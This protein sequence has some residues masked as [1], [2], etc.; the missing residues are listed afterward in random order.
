MT[1][2]PRFRDVGADTLLICRTN[3]RVLWTD[4]SFKNGISGWA[5][6]EEET[7]LHYDWE[8]GLTSNLAEGVAIRDALR[9]L[10]GGSGIV[11]TDSS[12]WSRALNG[13]GNM[14]GGAANRVMEE[15]RSM[16]HPSLAVR[17]VPSHTKH[18]TGNILADQYAKHA[19]VHQES[20]N[21]SSISVPPMSSE[22]VALVIQ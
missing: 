4:A 16:L 17:W 10:Q 5:V 13:E 15:C 6:V 7:C 19:R 2:T 18:L 11:L 8:R 3:Q 1:L 14:K 20:I 22:E 21:Q 9:I 12:S